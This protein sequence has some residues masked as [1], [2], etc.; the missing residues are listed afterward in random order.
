MAAPT[1]D[2]GSADARVAL[3]ARA[4]RCR[5]GAFEAV[6]GI[7]LTVHH[8]EV[9]A[10]L[11]TNGA[12]KTTTLETLEGHRAADAGTV[13][14]LGRDPRA[15]RRRL[16]ARIGVMFQQSGLPADLTPR[17]MLTLWS[18]LTPDAPRHLEVDEVL[19]RVEL[20]HRADVRIRQLSGGERR[21]LELGI[22]LINDPELIFLDEPTTGMDPEARVRTWGIIRGLLAGGATVVLTTHYLEE[23]ET[24]ADR[25]AIMHEGRLAA[26]G[27]LAEV[28]AAQPASIRARLPQAGPAPPAFS[29]QLRVDPARRLTVTTRELQRD[30]ALLLRWAEDNHLVLDQLHATEASLAQVFHDIAGAQPVEHDGHTNREDSR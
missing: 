15:D 20:G 17:E 5:Y 2:D 16:A 23:A 26:S 10:L 11:G 7:D 13:E 12:G 19:A 3:A 24:L 14:V 22:A 25:L 29:G 21:R 28:I 30:L 27:T 18:Q 6:R 4:L 1:R 9:F 8:G